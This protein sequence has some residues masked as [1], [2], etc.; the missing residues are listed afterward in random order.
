[1]PQ[2]PHRRLP[3][4]FQSHL[5]SLSGVGLLLGTL[6]FAASLT[7]TL[8]PRT[9]VTQGVL[10]GACLAA[11]YGLGVLWH[12]L[13]AYLELPEPQGRTA[14]IVNGAIT[15]I[16]AAV[17]LAFLWRAADWQ[18]TIRALMQMPPVPSAHPFKV[19]IT[20]LA[21]FAVL[22][23]LGRLFK[24][25]TRFVAVRVRRV[26]P[27]RVANVTG[28]AIAILIFWSLA[29]NVF[30]RAALHVLD[31]SFR[32]YDALLEPE[33]PRPTASNKT[34]G[35]DSLIA[36]Q[37]LGRAGREF[38][39]SGA[40]AADIR[41]QTG[42]DALEPI[43]VYVGLPGAD[44]PA[45]RAKLA[46][47]EMKRVGAFDRSTLVVVTPTGTG[48]IDPAAMDALEY[49]LHGDVASVGLQYSYLSSPLSL[50]AQPEYGSE[51]ARA[52][53]VEVYGYWTTLPKDK[54][55][56]LYLHGL[57]LG[58]MNSARSAELFEMIGDPIQGALWS[59]PPFESRVWRAITDAR[60]PGSPAWRPELRDGAF[61]RFMN[62]QGSP[63]PADAP[64]GP[65][66]IVFLQYASDAITF[67]D[68]RDLY[69]R[70]AWMDPPYGPDVSPQLRWVPV[71]TMLQ[72]ALDMSVSTDTPLGY[73]H[74]YAPQHYVDAW[75]AVTGATGWTPDALARLK[76][77]LL[78][79]AHAAL[80]DGDNAH[81][82]YEHRGG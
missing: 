1:M 33:R 8:V 58:A 80:A 42:Q 37:Q 38:I 21:T 34:G 82:A 56:K 68:F 18:N 70:P 48:W 69:R 50:L 49:L 63:V 64:W 10:G 71:V 3:A 25:V 81:A 29:N 73:G 60:N 52:L 74:V 46:L 35:P 67:F 28:A 79:R 31:A 44:T 11:G 53:F 17:L 36:W 26:V 24:L 72:L 22:L 59:G 78:D 15:L 43:R 2:G 66:R 4:F 76:Q 16:C 30:F 62:Q 54:R 12:W 55:P 13:W 14:R 41:A 27:R 65:M 77:H 57:S 45:A 7:P 51:A 6:F 75:L 47:A 9:Y 39:A 61:V 5:E 23:A 19:C 20:A 40:S 32:E